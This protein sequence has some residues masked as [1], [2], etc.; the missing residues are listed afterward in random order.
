[1]KNLKLHTLF[2][3]K[4]YGVGIASL[5]L[6]FLI[7]FVYLYPLI[8]MLSMSFMD[9][10]DIVDP[11]V[12]IIPT[13]LSFINYVQSYQVLNLPKSLWNSFWLSTLLAIFQTVSSAMAG[14]AFARFSFKGKNILLILVLITY[15][16]PMQVLTIPRFMVFS[17]YNLVGSVLPLLTV[18]LFGQG[19]NSPIFILIF[20]NFFRMQPPSIDEA[21]RID[22]ASYAQVFWRI[23]MALSIPVLTV[24]FMFS[25]VW[26]WN[27]TYVTGLVAAGR[28]RTLPLELEGFVAS[29]NRLFVRP[30]STHSLINEAIRMAGTMIAISPLLAIYLFLQRQFVE[31]IEKTGITGE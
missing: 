3:I 13:K 28:F 17:F 25:F 8:R 15:I 18:A 20:Y 26:N 2:S 9:S 16:V 11:N 7:G 24:A 22:G 12:G 5:V 30:G 1:M 10:R 19:L 29:Y 23:T 21:A 27:E 31:G 4:K 6:L 14:Y